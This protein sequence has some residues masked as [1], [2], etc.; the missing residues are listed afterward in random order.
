MDLDRFTTR[1]FPAAL[2]AR[3]SDLIPSHC[4]SVRAHHEDD[5]TCR[6][7]GHISEAKEARRAIRIARDEAETA[8]I[9]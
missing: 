3:V 1:P 4:R 6:L 8:H 5:G 7:T 9:R 2:L